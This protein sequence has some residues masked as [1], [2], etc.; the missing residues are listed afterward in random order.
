LMPVT[1]A[2]PGQAAELADSLSMA[3]ML[4]LEALGPAERAVFLLREV[5]GYDYAETAAIVDKSEA[6]CRQI[7]RRAKEHLQA[8]A[9]PP[10]PPTDQARRLVEE[11]LAAAE[12]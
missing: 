3:F 7:V 4:M 12:S 9:K 5:F 6:N 10:T 2:D 8:N 11:F 1:E